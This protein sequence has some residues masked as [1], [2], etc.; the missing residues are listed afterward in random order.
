MATPPSQPKKDDDSLNLINSPSLPRL[1]PSIPAN[2]GLFDTLRR[3]VNN[4][5]GQSDAI[6]KDTVR[7][8]VL[9]V[10]SDVFR[11]STIWLQ[12][13]TVRVR[14]IIT[15]KDPAHNKDAMMPEPEDWNDNAWINQ[16]T[17]YT[18]NLDDL[19][20]VRPTIGADIMVGFRNPAMVQ[21]K[22]GNGIIVKVLPTS[23]VSGIQDS[24]RPEGGRT[25]KIAAAFITHPGCVGEKTRTNIKPISGGALRGKNK[26]RTIGARNPRQL[27]SPTDDPGIFDIFRRPPETPNNATPT[28]APAAPNAPD[29]AGV[30]CSKVYV[31]K[32]FDDTEA[33]EA[34]LDQQRG[35]RCTRPRPLIKAAG[36]TWEQVG[37]IRGRKYT[38]RATKLASGH[39]LDV[40][41]AKAFTEM[42]AAAAKENV[43]IK[44]NSA[45]RL[46]EEQEYF[47]C[48]YKRGT[49]NLAARPGYSN[50]QSGAALDL[51]TRGIPHDRALRK[52]TGRSTG[53]GAVYDWL[54]KNGSKYGFKRIKR[55]HWHWNHT[56]TVNSN[57]AKIS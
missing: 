40:R 26:D 16:Y 22:F 13:P 19:G 12:E 9:R 35:G 20:G 45:F 18:A 53:K 33:T 10:D 50:H 49:G 6:P 3:N 36:A 37:F 14:A 7:A 48:K 56:P 8:K 52:R 1:I 24:P 15:E 2:E 38:F 43:R 55:E 44:I 47:Y 30:D 21:Q 32:D 23:K 31:M 42:Q 27:N 46:P 5:F 28:V 29:S 34:E 41:V 25:R 54:I 39:I 57:R 4:F 11:S 51:N 17:E